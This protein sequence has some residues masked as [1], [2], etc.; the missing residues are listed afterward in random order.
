MILFIAGIDLVSMVTGLNIGKPDDASSIADSAI[1][2]SIGFTEMSRYGEV[3]F[4]KMI[5][6][7]KH[8]CV[9]DKEVDCHQYKNQQILISIAQQISQSWQKN[10]LLP[11]HHIIYIFVGHCM[12]P[13]LLIIPTA[14]HVLSAHAVR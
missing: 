10:W 3:S 7:C 9:R 12:W 5:T 2:T 8:A 14:G 1:A 4:L 11:E 6:P 13:Y